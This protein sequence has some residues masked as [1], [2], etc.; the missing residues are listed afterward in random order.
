LVQARLTSTPRSINTGDHQKEEQRH[1]AASIEVAFV[2]V[3][4]KH[5][6]VDSE[7]DA[8]DTG[9]AAERDIHF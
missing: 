6:S 3:G 5:Q 9:N 8:F 2:S 1:A 7:H 4:Q